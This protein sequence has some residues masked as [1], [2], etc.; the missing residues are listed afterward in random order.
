MRYVK[1]I[2]LEI[3][4]VRSFFE[5]KKFRIFT[6]STTTTG[7][8]QFEPGTY[9]C[10]ILLY[11]KTN[12]SNTPRTTGT[13]VAYS[14][15]NFVLA[16]LVLVGAQQNVTSWKDYDMARQGLGFNDNSFVFL[17]DGPLNRSLDVGGTSVQY[18]K[19]IVYVVFECAKRARI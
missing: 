14:S 1:L 13:Q 16:G 2:T 19:T 9:C 15:T 4:S 10:L 3:A 6:T 12:N 7:R 17:T 11:H 18:G 5:L 8:F